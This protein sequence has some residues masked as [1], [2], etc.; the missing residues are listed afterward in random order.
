MEPELIIEL[1]DQHA[2]Q[3]NIIERLWGAFCEDNHACDCHLCPAYREGQ[4]EC[5][6]GGNGKK[7]TAFIESLQ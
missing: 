1:M 7:I 4:V 5:K 2:R 3:Q 6:F